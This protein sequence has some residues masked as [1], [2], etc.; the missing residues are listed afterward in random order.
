[1]EKGSIKHWI[2]DILKSLLFS[3]LIST[4]LVLVL[5]LIST[6]TQIS[7]KA[8]TII[9]QIIKVISLPIGCLLGI[10]SQKNG[11]ILGLIIGILYVVLSFGI[12]SLISGELKFSDVT[13]YDFL[14]GIGVGAVGGILAVNVK[15]LGKHGK[16]SA[17]AVRS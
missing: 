5:A 17:K 6:F 14:I 3:L 16:R 13:L 7:D 11:L 9:N 8:V 10:K 4:V 1:M 2:F 15:G 12:F